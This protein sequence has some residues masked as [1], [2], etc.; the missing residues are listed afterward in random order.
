MPSG[1]EPSL[2]ISCRRIDIYSLS[3]PT[4][5]QNLSRRA[6][7]VVASHCQPQLWGS[8]RYGMETGWRQWLWWEVYGLCRGSQCRWSYVRLSRAI[9]SWRG[10]PWW[11]LAESVSIAPG[12]K[13]SV[14]TAYQPRSSAGQ[15]WHPA[16]IA[17]SIRP[18]LLCQR[19]TSFSASFRRTAPQAAL[20]LS[21]DVHC[22]LLVPKLWSAG[23]SAFQD[24]RHRWRG[25]WGRADRGWEVIWR[26]SSDGRRLC[27][28]LLWQTSAVALQ[29]SRSGPRRVVGVVQDCLQTAKTQGREGGSPFTTSFTHAR[30]AKISR[31]YSGR[32]RC[33]M[34]APARPL[35]V[36][37][38]RGLECPVCRNRGSVGG[39]SVQRVR[40]RVQVR[41]RSCVVGHAEAWCRTSPNVG[42][43]G[44]QVAMICRG[45]VFKGRTSG[46]SSHKQPAPIRAPLM[47]STRDRLTTVHNP[48]QPSWGDDVCNHFRRV[49]LCLPIGPTSRHRQAG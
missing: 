2:S 20:S 45:A 11:H 27:A 43:G 31:L 35:P 44:S 48:S 15:A 22:L 9:W 21:A 10:G 1:V 19:S 40:A 13:S 18:R 38:P 30:S 47:H 29:A 7:C 42:G 36:T 39:S 4:T 8:Q 5:T 26:W 25:E 3:T 41:V 6:R 32:R 28:V 37:T 33:S 23:Q 16:S 49:I 46:L 12:P 14:K 17:P 34:L 24:P